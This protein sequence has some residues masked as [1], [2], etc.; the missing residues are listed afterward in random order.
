VPTKLGIALL[1]VT[2]G[3]VTF[4]ITGLAVFLAISQLE[5]RSQYA[6]APAASVAMT[7]YAQL[8]PSQR[9]PSR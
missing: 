3:G 4:L 7:Q 1:G 5:E 6:R 9:P 2:F 8:P